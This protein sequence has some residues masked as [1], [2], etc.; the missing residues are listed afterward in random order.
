MTIGETNQPL[1]PPGELQPR[2]KLVKTRAPRTT[3]EWLCRRF[4]LALYDLG[5]S[6]LLGRSWAT[7]GDDSIDFRSLSVKEADRLV[8]LLENLGRRPDYPTV[9]VPGPR[10]AAGR[11]RSGT[12]Q[13]SGYEQ[14]TLF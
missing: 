6:D 8:F 4:D 7:A 9:S 13:D 12:T 2:L 3:E 14:L 11:Q 10:G 5:L 1:E